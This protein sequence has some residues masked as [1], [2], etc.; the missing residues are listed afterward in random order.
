ML[1]I[2]DI[3]KA[4]PDAKSHVCDITADLNISRASALMYERFFGLSLIPNDPNQSIAELSKKAFSRLWQ[5]DK[6]PELIVHCHTLLSAGPLRSDSGHPTSLFSIED[7]E[8][9]SATMCHCAS[10]VAIFEL[11]DNLLPAGSTA[12]VIISDKAFHPA[13]QHIQN[14]TIMGDGAVAILIGRSGGRFHYLGS[15]TGRFGEYSIITGR[16]GEETDLDFAKEY[17][18]IAAN[19]ILAGLEAANTDVEQLRLILPHNVNI[20]SWEAIA[21][22]IGARRDQ[23]Y[24]KNIP[25]YGHTFGADSFLNLLDA[26]RAGDIEPGDIVALVSV[27]LGVTAS[28]AVF[29]VEHKSNPS[30][31]GNAND[32]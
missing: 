11:I 9:F 13:I 23:V 19:T 21:R 29:R 24:F 15:A 28:C 3:E 7:G 16:V 1:S 14:T 27:G 32:C 20:P 2:L 4:L 26:D 17:I 25:H 8:I 31:K 30:Q 18:D 10:G 22:K 5:I 6:T 12:L